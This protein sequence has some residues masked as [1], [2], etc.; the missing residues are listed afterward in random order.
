MKRLISFIMVFAL[1]IG[2]MP[3]PAGAEEVQETGTVPES[4]VESMPEE[5][6]EESTQ[7][8]STDPPSASEPV[9]ET[10]PQEAPETEATLETQ[11]QATVET[12]PEEP[13]LLTW[14]GYHYTLLP[15]GTIS[16][17]GFTGTPEEADR[18]FLVEIPVSIHGT[19]VTEIAGAAFA[20]NCEIDA[21]LLP[22]TILV[23]GNGAFEGCINLKV[24]AFSGDAPS[25]G[26]SILKGCEN[27]EEIDIPENRDFASLTA[28]LEKDLGEEAAR[29]IRFRSFEDPAA[30]EARFAALGDTTKETEPEAVMDLLPL[31]DSEP[32]EEGTV[33][34]Q[35]RYSYTGTEPVLFQW[36]YREGTQDWEAIPEA[37]GSIL[38]ITGISPET[39]SE[40]ESREYRCVLTAGENQWITNT[41]RILTYQHLMSADDV[42]AGD[43]QYSVITLESGEKAA[44][45]T[46]YTGAD[47][48]VVIP[49]TIDGYP[50]AKIGS[51]AFTNKTTVQSVII[52]EGVTELASVSSN[53]G[54]FKGCTS[55]TSVTLPSTLTKIGAHAF[56]ECTALTEIVLPDNVEMIG[57]GAFYGCKALSTVT[58]SAKL[59][60]IGSSAFH[61]CESLTALQLPDGLTT[62]YGSAFNGTGITRLELPDS[63]TSVDLTGLSE[64][65]TYIRWT[66]GIPVISS[67]RFDSFTALETVV[68]PEG[69]TELQDGTYSSN[70]YGC[71][72]SCSN[73]TNVSL[74]ST[75]T[76]IGDCAFFNCETLSE[77]ML[78][79]NIESIGKYAFGG[80]KAL[81]TVTLSVKL[82]SIGSYAFSR[83]ESLTALELPD[84]LET[85]GSYAFN[86]T[87]ITKLEL[88]DSV[89]SADLRGLSEYLTY[90]RWTVGIPIISYDR[91]CGFTALET[92]ILPEG[93][94]E[95]QDGACSDSIYG[96]FE[97]CSN[98]TN[99]SLPS[100][101]TK[102]GDYAFDNC[103]ALTD[104]VLPEN[105]ES[106]GIYAFY[107][108]KALNTITLPGKLKTIGNYT[109]CN[110]ASLTALELSDGL[111]TI[112]S[113]AFSG[114]ASLTALKLPDGLKTIGSYA[115]DGTR[116]AKL[117]LPDS[118]TSVDLSGLS[119]YLT[120]I[121]W[122]AGIP[123]ISN[124]RFRNFT[125]LETVLIPEGVTTL[126]DG[127][128]NSTYGIYGS[129]SGCTSLTSVT[130]PSSLT[131]IGDYSFYNCTSLTEIV[132]PENVESIGY[133][134]F[135]GC[136]VLST[137][138]LAA[139]L[140]SI[141]SYAFSGC[142][143]LIALELPDGLE[144]IG[145]YAFSGTKIT[146]LELPDSVTEVSLGGLSEQL[147]YIRWTAGI[148]V[149]SN[150]FRNYTALE[151]VV[152]P[153]GVTALEDG[154]T[155]Y[156]TY[157]SFSGC[158]SLTS[159]T[160][161][162]S[163]TKIGDYSFCN[164]TALTAI[165]LPDN[166]ESIGSRAFAY[167]DNLQRIQFGK[168]VSEIASNA[169]YGTTDFTAVVWPGSPAEEYMIQY[170]I[171]YIYV[172][173]F[174]ASG[175]L[176]VTLEPK[177]YKGMQL[178]LD[179]G[180]S[181][182]TRT[183]T[184]ESSY[185]FTGLR[186]D[187]VCTVQ[188]VNA[189]GDVLVQYEN[190]AIAEDGALEITAAKNFG[191]LS[192]RLLDEDGTDQTASAQIRWYDEAGR[193]YGT[194][195]LLKSALAGKVLT[196]RIQLDDALGHGY[197]NPEP[198]I[199]TVAVG[200]NAIDLTLEPITQVVLSGTV[201]DAHGAAVSASVAASQT[202][203]DKYHVQATVVTDSQGAF[204]MTVPAAPAR[205]TVHAAGY[206]SKS[207]E[208]TELRE[209]RDLG[210]LTLEAVSG[211]EI[212]F[213]LQY[214]ET[215]LEE[216]A[217]EPR[218]LNSLEDLDIAVYNR[219]QGANV[220]NTS[221]QG[222]RVI[223]MDG[224][225]A[226]D[227]LEI[228]ISN[229]RG[230]VKPVSA[231]VTLDKDLKAEVSAVLRENGIIR[232]AF[233]TTKNE[234]VQMLVYDAAGKQAFSVNAPGSAGRVVSGTLAEGE[235]TVVLMGASSFFDYPNSLDGLALA[236]L[237]QDTD[238]V[239]Q[240]VSVTAGCVTECSFA[241]VPLLVESRFYYTDPD[242]TTFTASKTTVSAG[243]FFTLRSSAKFAANY[244]GKVS[245]IRWIIEL[246]EGTE[247]YPGTLTVGKQAADFAQTDNRLIIPVADPSQDL[248][249]CVLA[250]G[251]GEVRPAAYLQFT[252]AGRTIRQPVGS[253]KV[254][255]DGLDFEV[256]E[257]TFEPTVT[258]VGTGAV[259]SDILLFDNDV[260]VGQT[261]S[262]ASGSWNLT[263]DL[264]KPESYSTHRL[265]A[266]M[267]LVT[268]TKVRSTAHTVVYQYSP[269][270]PAVNTVSMY[271]GNTSTPTSV[272]DFKNHTVSRSSYSVSGSKTITF[273]TDFDCEDMSLLSDV[274]LEVTQADGNIRTL[275]TIYDEKVDGF[276]ASGLFAMRAMPVNVAVSYCY[277][278]EPIFSEG[279]W[280]EMKEEIGEVEDI[281]AALEEKEWDVPEGAFE[282][283]EFDPAI[284]EEV[285]EYLRQEI[286][287]YNAAL[288]E[289]KE[290]IKQFQS[291]SEELY[292]TITYTQQGVS[293]SGGM[294]DIAME[295]YQLSNFT[296]ADKIAE[297]YDVYRIGE[298]T[299]EFLLMRITSDELTGVVECTVI[300]TSNDGQGTAHMAQYLMQGVKLS[301][302]VDVSA[303]PEQSG[304]VRMSRAEIKEGMNK[305]PEIVDLHDAFS[306]TADYTQSILNDLKDIFTETAPKISDG[307]DTLSAKL[308]DAHVEKSREWQKITDPVESAAVKKQL[309]LEYQAITKMDKDASLLR[310]GSKT[311]DEIFGPAGDILSAM[312]D[313]SQLC[314]DA[315]DWL[316]MNKIQQS[317]GDAGA[318]MVKHALALRMINSGI[319]LSIAVAELTLIATGALVSAPAMAAAIGTMTVVSAGVSLWKMREWAEFDS[320]IEEA[321]KLV[322]QKYASSKGGGTPLKPIVD[323]SGFVYEAVLSNRLPD[324][325]VTCYEQVT[326]YDIY[327]EPY[328]EVVLW[329][330]GEYEQENPLLTDD[331]GQY[332]WDVPQGLWQ[333]KA[334]L[335]GYETAYSDW[336]TVPP[337]QLDVNLGMISYAVPEMTDVFAQPDSVEISFSKYMQAETLTEDTITVTVDA[338]A[339]PGTIELLNAEAAAE[340]P[341]KTL[342]SRIRFVPQAPLAD[343]VNVTVSVSAEA[344][345]YA[346]V[347]VAPGETRDAAVVTIP[348]SLFAAESLRLVYQDSVALSIQAQPAGLAAGQAVRVSAV[349]GLLLE[350][351]EDT[352]ILDEDGCGVVHITGKLPGETELLFTMC[353]GK[354]QA[355]TTVLIQMPETE[356]T[357]Q[358]AQ[359]LE[360]DRQYIVL[361]RN[362]SITLNADVQP[363]TLADSV[364]WKI[365][366]GGEKV[367]AVD[368]SGKVTALNPGTA[369]VLAEVGGVT[370]RC[371]VDVVQEAQL[372]GV[373]L[374]T[375]TL[376]TELFSR[377]YAQVDVCLLLRQNYPTA[378]SSLYA[379]RSAAMDT[380]TD[381]GIT[382]DG[383][384][385]TDD[386]MDALFALK[387]ADDRTLAVIPRTSALEASKSVKSSYSGTITLTIW[388]QEYTTEALKLI[389]KK[390][391]PKLTAS[392]E[393][394]NSFYSGQS[395]PIAV[396][397]GTVT[398][399]FENTAKKD[400]VPGWLRLEEG[401][402]TLTK[403]APLANASGKAYLL[404]ETEEWNV[405]AEVTLTVKNS[406]AAP[407]LK[408]SASSVSICGDWESSSG[409]KLQLQCKNKKDTPESLNVSGISAPEGYRIGDY[410][411]AD[412]SFTLYAEEDFIPGKL[413]LSVSFTDTAATLP[414]PLSVKTAPV[415]L[416]LSKTSISLNAKVG[417]SALIGITAAPADY[418]L[419]APGFRLTD[420]SGKDKLASGEL[421][422]SCENGGIR[423]STTDKTLIGGTY[424]LFVKAG[425]SKEVALTIKVIGS[426]PSVSLSQSA[427]LDLSLPNQPAAVTASFK[428]YTSGEV[429][430]FAYAVTEMKGSTLLTQNVPYFTVDS[431]DGST[432]QVTCTDPASVTVKNSY[433]LNLKLTLAD[434]TKC[435]ASLKLKV[436]QTPIRLKLTPGKLTLNKAVSDTASVFVQ[437][438]VKGYAFTK[439]IWQLMDSSGK[440]PMDG[441]LDIH[442]NAGKL[443]VRTNEE[444]QYGAAYKLLI[445]AEEGAPPETLTVTI[446]TEAKSNV[447]STLSLKGSLDVIRDSS[448][449]TVTPI[450]KNCAADTPRTEELRILR[451]DS[452]DVTDLFQ[453]TKNQNGTFT[454]AKARGTQI[455]L[456]QK[457]QVMLFTSFNGSPVQSKFSNLS[458]KMGSAQMNAVT[459]GT[460]F[461]RDKNSRVSIR[462]TPNDAQLNEAVR[463]EMKDSKYQDIFEIYD[464]GN[465]TF[466]IGFREGAIPDLP[467]KPIDLKLNVFLEGN[468]SAK[469]NTT[470]SL[471]LSIVP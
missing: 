207:L 137:I 409:V 308:W 116:I 385:F 197:W 128:S 55:L 450:Y 325:T 282:P 53:D 195:A 422:I 166:V 265:Y 26:A 263:F 416:K 391:M 252:Y 173:D 216:D 67:S 327:D 140:K 24:M 291:L 196:V 281:L 99:V 394:F 168:N 368:A 111:E 257:K 164:C 115:F 33:K 459:E 201:M 354:L 236:D 175:V 411:A 471:K 455:D 135:C 349:S 393:P 312:F 18:P 413:S 432:F 425:G 151:T 192:L 30:L 198:I 160:L 69:V 365:E 255:I 463:V 470:V 356:E 182:I 162:S 240:K 142:E 258:V 161:P 241:Q 229:V 212:S 410:N 23:M 456:T 444:T 421:D 87:R 50:V 407:G 404:V 418:I 188:I 73:L 272:I 297:G 7:T 437:C 81:S 78:P 2:M 86:A 461:T 205:I 269:H 294:I 72:S 96:C 36:Q 311:V 108:C 138:T 353:D 336:L 159:V 163:L 106:I 186:M 443:T 253:V 1:L 392:V 298:S 273:V 259:D 126:K 144:T 367:A 339:V 315:K 28:L 58:L 338:V 219:T 378:D 454:I 89:T 231:V 204:R 397:G 114:C 382:I 276:V 332:A 362:Q 43:F 85:I 287:K 261:R 278:G 109:F 271:Y 47:T 180:D 267:N 427:V 396:T 248:R 430:G 424:K 438:T 235:Y 174:D 170:G 406:Y 412:G 383:A 400:A 360:M 91:F 469:P 42:S 148:P 181:T 83:C 70:V 224:A 262:N 447:T 122:T 54:A 90:I 351:E 233:D 417:D 167:C 15:D 442:W 395:H 366:N 191:D 270:P 243:R 423:I 234:T 101:L 157:S 79:E 172:S 49:D 274:T 446:P 5:T 8:V 82:K 84:G 14:E 319:S 343:G 387:V 131:K 40:Y 434:G 123:V 344:V 458:V 146:K 193:P 218:N 426:E 324:A 46:G 95:L 305:E 373:A 200:N 71:F 61:T 239:L 445:C 209:D 284:E 246:P 133:R 141:G 112:G 466:A 376:T 225:A 316:D 371:R 38:E 237:V 247:Y 103:S 16:I 223:L 321:K 440:I 153:E 76:K 149:L 468:T 379:D 372:D 317:T 249:L 65:L 221:V 13:M 441:K 64:Q 127:S 165:V 143:R 303:L 202:L 57:Y 405:P 120:Y 22:G 283:F 189:Y 215:A 251:K 334:E 56:Y 178:V 130:L 279:H 361:C 345:S 347:A 156:G 415:Q 293:S 4:T 39:L 3:I 419:S 226:G 37:N 348:D 158:T 302:D 329:D 154:F 301:K 374:S 10:E 260:L 118:V 428:N 309:D 389:V 264:Y 320:N 377:E 92:V 11:P 97:G 80:C 289:Y 275:E 227:E 102:I 449:V 185:L 346:D 414:L 451:S 214:E 187:S 266:Q 230:S 77:I 452:T 306:R 296:I 100:T 238:Y 152:I 285:P 132:L 211:A 350:A 375:N 136:K 399:I 307:L 254:M 402:L 125:T 369:Y 94:T 147:I 32:D 104:I 206:L 17:R 51:S 139:K 183:I 171:D 68:I 335:Y 352:V 280:E 19:A 6:A 250:T 256:T 355:K 9:K 244:Q 330:A 286:G 300:D 363:R 453:I 179:F 117:E 429:S 359:A 44:S 105:V 420:H 390:S 62:I 34:F 313:V 199:H 145:F 357:L 12:Q 41:A 304:F 435:D 134:A 66:A 328:T 364:R 436:K 20:G 384:R 433:V 155:N 98:L 431:H 342:A 462:F 388:N 213:R 323:P 176:N 310:A 408:L 242:A 370:A 464:Y 245:D 63:V 169:F 48:N 380:L 184:D 190:I 467:A 25:F 150:T 93:V 337:P 292:G 220:E 228:T 333:V 208:L 448:T 113:Y 222:M 21:V 341:E 386:S 129:F 75:L 59:K 177:L 403:D 124:I 194:G 29:E 52:P 465:G 45:I 314:S 290:A 119:E 210:E 401:A 277:N 340:N 107:G 295:Q 110:C 27:L 460:L 318:E 381:A 288:V 60:T 74:P 232:A 31:E 88:P 203:N 398:G 457:Y 299:N 331:L 268:G 121:R 326:K 35:A 217:A 358:A 322:N 439:P